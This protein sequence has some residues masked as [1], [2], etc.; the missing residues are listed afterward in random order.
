MP[1]PEQYKWLEK[2]EQNGKRIHLLF[3]SKP[4]TDADYAQYSEWRS[5]LESA[6]FDFVDVHNS[7]T[8]QQTIEEMIKLS[9]EIEMREPDGG[10]REWM[11]FKAFRNTMRDKIKEMKD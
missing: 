7:Q 10:T 4:E 11:A 3:Y 1:N 8:R 6:I 2:I 9:D 5:D